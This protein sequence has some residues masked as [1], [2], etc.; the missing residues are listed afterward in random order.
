MRKIHLYGALADQCSAELQL[1]VETAGEAIRAI[2][3]QFPGALMVLREGS[4]HVVMGKEIEGGFDLGEEE[5]SR[6][7]LGHDDLHIL[8]AIA[9]AKTETATLKSIV[10]VALIGTAVAVSGGTLAAPLMAS[11][12]LS[13]ATWGN[14]AMIGLGLALSGVS[15]LLSP[16]TDEDDKKD[17][18]FVMNGPMNLSGQGN[19]VPLVYGE[20]ITGGVLVS[21][22]VDIEPIKVGV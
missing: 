12:I 17:T 22:G 11:G 9:G 19:P 18:S 20:V 2:I 13:G 8:P 16:E 3:S 14:V 7:R 4:Y 5:I 10:G 1:E 15:E 21:G 6:F